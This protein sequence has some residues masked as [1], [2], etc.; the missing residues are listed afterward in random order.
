MEE[1]LR[2]TTYLDTDSPAVQSFAREAVGD[3]ATEQ[4]KAIRLFYAVRDGIR[5][6]PYRFGID[7]ATFVASAV[8]EAKEAFCVPKAI[9]L[10]AAA[11]VVGIPSRLNFADVRNHLSSPRLLEVLQTDVF[12]FHGSTELFLDGRWIKVTPAFN[13]TLCEKMKVAPLDFDGV[14]ETIFQP[15]DAAGQ[16]FME[17]LHDHGSFADLPYDQM[18]AAFHHHYGHLYGMEPIEG[19]MEKEV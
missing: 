19:D 7:P 15:F 14:H 16:Q 9:L 10:A 5:Y 12:T 8:L 13:K 4:E 17:Y 6:N 2:P 3:A 1:F 11:R 18:L